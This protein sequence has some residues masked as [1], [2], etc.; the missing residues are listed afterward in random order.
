M[1]SQSDIKDQQ[2]IRDLLLENKALE[3][4]NQML[5]VELDNQL[6]DY[7]YLSDCLENE[8]SKSNTL[9][10]K[11]KVLVNHCHFL[12]VQYTN[13][14]GW[15]AQD[16][17]NLKSAL[18]AEMKARGDLLEASQKDS[19]FWK[20]EY[21]D[22]VKV[23]KRQLILNKGLK[24]DK[25]SL[26][27]TIDDL[28]DHVEQ[29]RSDAKTDKHTIV[30]LT[31]QVE[32]ITLTKESQKM[33][34]QLIDMTIERDKFKAKAIGIQEDLAHWHGKY[35]DLVKENKEK[36]KIKDASENKVNLSQSEIDFL[37]SYLSQSLK[38]ASQSISG[39]KDDAKFYRHKDITYSTW[40][41]KSA[42]KLKKKAKVL[43][44]IQSKL[45]K[46]VL[47]R[48]VEA[49]V[50][51]HEGNQEG[52]YGHKQAWIA[53]CDAIEVYYPKFLSGS[54]TGIEC[55]VRAVHTL[56]KTNEQWNKIEDMITL[57]KE[58]IK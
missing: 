54:G 4:N 29:L 30:E 11:N 24:E 5:K 48:E 39:L 13:K 20:S 18:E 7:G 42:D 49:K 21:E 27:A 32:H 34:N 10:E 57:P 22:A 51:I 41:Y 19:E 2:L 36:S 9:I 40:C 38:D 31:Y 15:M 50:I 52:Y 1:N 35:W 28:T 37:K 23:L 33:Y 56:G 47:N 53:V 25:T 14:R 6:K 55:A 17:Q 58:V 46:T 43:S 16:N 12:D 45:K 44:G 26:K 8:L 3:R